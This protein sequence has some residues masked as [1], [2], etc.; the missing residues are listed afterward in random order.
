MHMYIY[1]HICIYI[2]MNNHMHTHSTTNF[3]PII[4]FL[5]GPIRLPM[6][7]LTSLNSFVGMLPLGFLQRCS[8]QAESLQKQLSQ[9]HLQIPAGSAWRF[10]HSDTRAFDGSIYIVSL[11]SWALL[12]DGHKPQIQTRSTAYEQCKVEAKEENTNSKERCCFFRPMPF[13]YL[14][15]DFQ[16]DDSDDLQDLTESD[17]LLRKK[18]T[19]REAPWPSEDRTPKAFCQQSILPAKHCTILF[20]TPLLL[21]WTGPTHTPTPTLKLCGWPSLPGRLRVHP[22]VHPMYHD[23]Q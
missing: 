20:L 11:E 22:T 16:R 19:L 13:R 7:I 8:W 9:V 4:C 14:V 1:M 23:D 15:V 21:P 12:S 5:L 6:P 2:Y 3:I 10:R 17:E 18:K